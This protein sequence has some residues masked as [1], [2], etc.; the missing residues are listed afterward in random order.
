MCIE[1]LREK[2]FL[3]I[4][5]KQDLD[6]KGENIEDYLSNFKGAFN[7]ANNIAM[8]YKYMANKEKDKNDNFVG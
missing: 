4:C 7:K 6:L 1:E 8:F 5:D 3:Q 2:L